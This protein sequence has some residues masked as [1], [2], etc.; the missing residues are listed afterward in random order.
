M[1]TLESRAAL[2]CRARYLH[3]NGDP[4]TAHSHRI[5]GPSETTNRG[6]MVH[7]CARV[8]RRIEVRAVIGFLATIHRRPGR[9]RLAAS[10][11][12]A[13]V[14]TQRTEPLEVRRLRRCASRIGVPA[15]ARLLKL[16]RWAGYGAVRAEHAAVTRLRTQQRAA[17]CAFVEELAGVRRHGLNM[18]MSAPRTGQSALQFWISGHRRIV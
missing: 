18:L 7:R 14:E 11:R 1:V 16:S 3:R 10:A 12:A 6:R 2:T 4:T 17:A 13:I 8:R 15:A 5:S 9:D